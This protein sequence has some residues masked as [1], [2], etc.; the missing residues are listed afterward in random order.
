MKCEN[1]VIYSVIYN[2]FTKELFSAICGKGSFLND[3][4]IHINETISIEKAL[5]A[6]GTSPYY[7]DMSSV[8]FKK[9]EAVYNK[10]LDIRRTG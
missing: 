5:V 10:A 1:E 4:R 3:V 8:V 9:I 6:V 2:P 7:K